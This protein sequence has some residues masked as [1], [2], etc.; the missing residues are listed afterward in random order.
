M[1]AVG[2]FSTCSRLTFTEWD[3]MIPRWRKYSTLDPIHLDK[4]NEGTP[5]VLK[6]QATS[7]RKQTL[8]TTDRNVR[9]SWNEHSN[10]ALFSVTMGS[11]KKLYS[12]WSVP[13]IEPCLVL[14]HLSF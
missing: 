2:C 9:G 1:D 10:L 13:E 4:D 12:D 5:M 6:A 11:L 8:R 14:V 7:F 3:P